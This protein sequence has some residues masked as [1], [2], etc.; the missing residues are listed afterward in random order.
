MYTAGYVN[1]LKN[2]I[3]MAGGDPNSPPE[4]TGGDR[5]FRDLVNVMSKQVLMIGGSS[6]A[7]IPETLNRVANGMTTGIKDNI[8]KIQIRKGRGRIFDIIKNA[9]KMFG[10]EGGA[11]GDGEATGDGNAEGKDEATGDGKA[12]D[13]VGTE[14]EVG[15]DDEVKSNSEHSD[16][17]RPTEIGNS[18]SI[19]NSFESKDDESESKDEEAILNTDSAEIPFSPEDPDTEQPEHNQNPETEQPKDGKKS[20]LEEAAELVTNSVSKGS[21]ISDTAAAVAADTKSNEEFKQEGA[22]R[23]LKHTRKRTPTLNTKITHKNRYKTDRE[24]IDGNINTI[25]S[26]DAEIIKNFMRK[27]KMN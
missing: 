9:S 6:T 22:K 15:A 10:G 18:S 20:V 2:L 8:N 3:S 21:S 24:N 7:G 1:T 5:R 25:P 26:N 27:N 19:D 17:P 23:V 12:D 14:S 16:S 13:E 4:T 11:T